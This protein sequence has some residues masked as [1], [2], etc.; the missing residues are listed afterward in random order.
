MNNSPPFSVKTF[1]N[2]TD[3][4]RCEYGTME[5]LPKAFRVGPLFPRKNRLAA[6]QAVQEVRKK[7]KNQGRILYDDMKKVA[8]EATA[9]K[10]L[11]QFVK[12]VRKVAAKKK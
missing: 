3:S 7:Q 1:I 8:E 6:N 11:K 9:S 10:G 5:T 12:A 2:H 4:T